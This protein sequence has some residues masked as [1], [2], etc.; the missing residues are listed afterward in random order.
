M[1]ELV[2]ALRQRSVIDSLNHANGVV[3]AVVSRFKGD[4]QAGYLGR[5]AQS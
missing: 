5:L 3:H 4:P 1:K 2:K